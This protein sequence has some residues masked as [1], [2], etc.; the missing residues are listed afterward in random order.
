A[1]DALAD[2][3]TI[4]AWMNPDSVA[5]N[6]RL[7]AHSQLN[8]NNG[9][10]FGIQNGV[11]RF[12]AYGV[13]H[14]L[15]TAAVQANTW[16]HVAVVFDSN[17]DAT[18]Y[19]NGVAVDTIPGN[20]PITL[21]HDDPLLIGSTTPIGSNVPSERFAGQMDELAIYGRAMSAAELVSIYLR[22]LRWFRAVG[23]TVLQVDDDAPTVELLTTH[24]YRPSGYTQLV[25]AS[26]D[27][28]SYVALLDVGVR[29]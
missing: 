26:S 7:V 18:F 9:I 5:G 3:L 8:S 6:Q 21:N 11:L 17:H 19:L 15:S 12:T 24:P 22:E 25:V 1:V 2:S 13:Q 4:M 23:T 10:G 29:P 27:P 20:A 16:Q 14:Y 28:S